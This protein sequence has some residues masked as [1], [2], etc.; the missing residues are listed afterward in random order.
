MGVEESASA[1]D[2]AAAEEDS[3]SRSH[4]VRARDFAHQPAEVL[5]QLL[6]CSVVWNNIFS[7]LHFGLLEGQLT[8]CKTAPTADSL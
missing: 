2:S 6:F 1:S 3:H 8:L 7:S 4:P 5:E